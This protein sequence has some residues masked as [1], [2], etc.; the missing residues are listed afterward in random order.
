MYSPEVWISARGIIGVDVHRIKGVK[1]MK[2]KCKTYLFWV[3]LSLGVGLMAGLLTRAGTAAY[4]INAVK[5]PLTPPGWLFPIVWTIL[6]TL[7][8]I[9]AARISLMLN[10][11]GRDQALNIFVVQLVVNF[12]WSL[13]FFNAKAYGLAFVWILLLWLLIIGMILSFLKVDRIAAYLQVPYML[14]V[15]FATYLNWGI[16]QLNR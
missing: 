1:F 10:A 3:G 12:F 7:M 14:W 15:T 11:P 8:G 9:G 6:Y 4:A 16:Y 2:Q 5:P 13:I